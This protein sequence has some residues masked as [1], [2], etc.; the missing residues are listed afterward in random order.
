M[1]G[2]GYRGSRYSFGYPACPK[3]EDQEQLL[4]LLK[5]A[6]IG[7]VLSDEYQLH[8][9]QPASATSAKLSASSVR[10][11]VMRS[12]DS[13]TAGRGPVGIEQIGKASCRE[14]VC[15]YVW[16]SVVEVSLKNKT[17]NITV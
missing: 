5:A 2:Q 13:T 11:R 12:S 3:L 16:I 14:R 15:Q 9:E 10:I 7:V 17:I 1:L 6:E 8:P 4:R